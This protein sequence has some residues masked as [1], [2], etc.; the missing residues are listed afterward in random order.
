MPE[1]NKTP[2]Q[3]AQ[4]H[5]AILDLIADEQGWN[6]ASKLAL[7]VEYISE[8]CDPQVFKN[9]LAEKAKDENAG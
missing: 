2:T 6:D 8:Y 3:D 1:K 9:F 7:C 5:Q 4:T